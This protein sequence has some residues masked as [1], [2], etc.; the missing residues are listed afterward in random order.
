MGGNVFLTQ[1]KYR[2][3]SLAAISASSR[4]VKACRQTCATDCLMNCTRIRSAASATINLLASE[5]PATDA[6]TVLKPYGSP[7]PS[8][9]VTL[10]NRHGLA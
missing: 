3:S 2:R 10:H 5:V 6:P 1:P 7:Q 8:P 9:A 4:E